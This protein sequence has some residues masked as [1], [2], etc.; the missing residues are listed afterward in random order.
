M[1][2]QQNNENGLYSKL[3]NDI[4]KERKKHELFSRS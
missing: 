2:E 3:L 1:S 4:N